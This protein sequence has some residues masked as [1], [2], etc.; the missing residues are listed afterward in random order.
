M[1]KYEVYNCNESFG[2]PLPQVFATLEEAEQY[3]EGV[4]EEIIEVNRAIELQAFWDSDEGKEAIQE[5]EE[6]YLNNGLRQEAKE[7]IVIQEL[8][9]Q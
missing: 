2:D 7:A 4:I 8:E 1:T 6:E 5:I 3:R 9:T